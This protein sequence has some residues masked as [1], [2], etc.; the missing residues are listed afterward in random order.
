[1]EN[2]WMLGQ[3][4]GSGVER[5]MRSSGWRDGGDE[6][7]TIPSQTSTAVVHCGFKSTLQIYWLCGLA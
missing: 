3:G 7:R 6:E 4:S 1:M 2:R 5:V